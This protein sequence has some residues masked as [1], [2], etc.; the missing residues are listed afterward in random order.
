VKHSEVIAAELP[1]ATL[2][3]LPGVGHMAM[4]E[5]PDVVDSALAEL[6]AEVRPGGVLRRL[7]KRA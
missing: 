4:L 2:L 7:R 6:L 5:E 3:C 1:D